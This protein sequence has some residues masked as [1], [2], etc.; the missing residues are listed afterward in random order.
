LATSEWKDSY[1]TMYIIGVPLSITSIILEA[2]A[3]KNLKRAVRIY[4][5]EETAPSAFL[6]VPSL[7][8]SSDG[9]TRIG[10]TWRF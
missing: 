7:F 1:T 6:P 10:L 4:N 5:G 9:K 2:G 8:A 3:T